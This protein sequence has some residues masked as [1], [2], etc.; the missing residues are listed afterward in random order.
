MSR[1]RGRGRSGGRGRGRGYQER[2]FEPKKPPLTFPADHFEKVSKLRSKLNRE[3]SATDKQISRICREYNQ[4]IDTSPFR[5][6]KDIFEQRKD[7][8][9]LRL[10]SLLR[11]TKERRKNCDFARWLKMKNNNKKTALYAVSYEKKH[12]SQMNSILSNGNTVY[13]EEIDPS[14]DPLIESKQLTSD[15]AQKTKKKKKP[16]FFPSKN[17]RIRPL[18][19]RKKL[20]LPAIVHKNAFF[21]CQTSP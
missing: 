6:K 8:S 2:T 13:P 3:A 5:V 18:V 16:P 11:M 10:S 20:G 4:I 9:P 12:E 7:L 21:K 19:G 17:L 15:M 1:G 14:R